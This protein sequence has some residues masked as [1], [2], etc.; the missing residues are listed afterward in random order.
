MKLLPL[1]AVVLLIPVLAACPSPDQAHETTAGL[2]DATQPGAATITPTPDVVRVPVQPMAG[3]ATA[4]EASLREV[5]ARTSV[6][7]TVRDAPANS[8]L[9]AH[10]HR[11]SCAE[12]GPV[13][14]PLEPIVTD[15]AGL[16]TSVTSVELPLNTVTQ[17]QFYVQA[18]AP[19]PD[20]S[21]IACGDIPI[22]A[23]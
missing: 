20:G 16:G 11:G 17:G 18:H 6:Q 12:Q 10:I 9:Q 21:P 15:G 19:D 22:Q 1:G 13:A 14:A 3:A 4:G 5:G 8:T 7:F 23:R 2:P